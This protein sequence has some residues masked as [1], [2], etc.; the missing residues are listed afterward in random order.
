MIFAF[1]LL[2]FTIKKGDHNRSYFFTGKR[3]NGANLHG[4]RQGIENQEYI[5]SRPCGDIK[6]SN[7]FFPSKLIYTNHYEKVSILII[8]SFM[9]PPGIQ[10]KRKHHP[11]LPGQRFPDPEFYDRREAYL[12]LSILAY[13]Y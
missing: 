2:I 13:T 9:G 11:D 3:R 5:F 8:C 7:S 1:L 10:P 12:V 6:F 4:G